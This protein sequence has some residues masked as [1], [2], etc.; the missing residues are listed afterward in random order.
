MVVYKYKN[1]CTIAEKERAESYVAAAASSGAVGEK[2][3]PKL[4]KN[5]TQ[6]G[7][8]L[9][10]FFRSVSKDSKTS[11]VA[12]EYKKA[13]TRGSSKT[14]SASSKTQKSMSKTTALNTAKVPT[15]LD[16]REMNEISQEAIKLLK[17]WT[18]YAILT[19]L[20]QTATLL[21]IVG[22]ILYNA[23]PTNAK[24][25]AA[26]ISRWSRGHNRVSWLEKIKLSTQFLEECKLFFFAWLRLLPTSFTSLNR[27]GADGKGNN[28][29][30]AKSSNDQKSTVTGSVKSH[31]KSLEKQSK[32]SASTRKSTSIRRKQPESKEV[33]FSNQPLDIMYERLAPIAVSLVSTSTNIVKD[34]SSNAVGKGSSGSSFESSSAFQSFKT[35]YIV[36]SRTVLEAMVWT[37]I[38]SEPTKNLILNTFHQCTSL[39]PAAI[40]MMMPSYFTNYGVIYVRLLVP[41]ANSSTT[42]DA[43]EEMKKEVEDENMI[44]SDDGIADERWITISFAMIRHLQY[45]TIQAILSSIL[46]SFAP[47]L[48]WVPLSTHMVWL[49][50]AY[51]Q[52]ETST[53]KLY[54]L[55]EWELVAFGILKKNTSISQGDMSGNVGGKEMGV[56]ET[57]TMQLVNKIMKKVPSSLTAG[58]QTETTET[59]T[60]ETHE[61]NGVASEKTGIN[62][63]MSKLGA[64][65]LS[66]N[67][68][69]GKVVEQ[70]NDEMKSS[71]QI[72]SKV[73]DSRDSDVSNEI[74]VSKKE[75]T[76]EAIAVNE[77]KKQSSNIS[78]DV[79]RPHGSLDENE[80]VCISSEA[81][82]KTEDKKS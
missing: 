70:S 7:S 9:L 57:M 13:A 8:G 43:F 30:Q 47:V 79:I 10:S 66:I 38:I 14:R 16:A 42:C 40:T 76:E 68:A 60:E 6:Q 58:N 12:D 45:W 22:R 49:V 15:T 29:T 77:V 1:L 39:L 28:F 75:P 44:I 21:P 51:A 34:T 53:K 48:A 46:L 20:I 33:P 26:S 41:C 65:D 69:K 17:Y 4:E 36:F 27:Q 23:N 2:D 11:S 32:L 55:L 5:K 62:E 67:P 50:W 81:D 18:V 31:I 54:A 3:R 72:T 24:K 19:A 64:S 71:T 35:K 80:Y 78:E 52:L 73:G 82:K 37:K 56:N 25:A 63:Q 74:K 61:N 59:E